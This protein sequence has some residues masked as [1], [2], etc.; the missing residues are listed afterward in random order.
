M[1][2]SEQQWRFHLVT[3]GSSKVVHIACAASLREMRGWAWCDS[4]KPDGT[5]QLHPWTGAAPG[6]PCTRCV[7]T[8][9]EFHGAGAVDLLRAA[10][11]ND[12]PPTT[13]RPER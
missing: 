13:G 7:N 8:L 4:G 10:V 2:P 1:E 6:R 3:L 11:A 12:Q 5:T 9:R